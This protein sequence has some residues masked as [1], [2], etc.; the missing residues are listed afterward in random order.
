[1]RPRGR[2][3]PNLEGVGSAGPRRDRLEAYDSLAEILVQSSAR[4]AGAT[5]AVFALRGHLPVS[6]HGSSDQ[7]VRELINRQQA[8]LPKAQV[9]TALSGRR[10]PWLLLFEWRHT[11][12]GQGARLQ[13]WRLH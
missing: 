13:M 3:T 2:P 7:I 6:P 5:G 8:K 9:E 12:I 10:L 1:M 11:P 4:S